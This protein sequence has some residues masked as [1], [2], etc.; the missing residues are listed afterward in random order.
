M[1]VADI[2][3]CAR[4]A[5]PVAYRSRRTHGGIFDAEVPNGPPGGPLNLWRSNV[6]SNVL[7]GSSGIALQGAGVFAAHL[8]KLVNSVIEQ[9][10]PDQCFGC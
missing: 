3:Q 7:S 9:N 4:R 10:T 8:V 6:T 2:G 5:G 1:P